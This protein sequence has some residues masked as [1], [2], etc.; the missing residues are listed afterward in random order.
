MRVNPDVGQ[1]E[2]WPSP[3][4]RGAVPATRLA[5]TR[6]IDIPLVAVLMLGCGIW[7]NLSWQRSSANGLPFF[8]Q[9]YFE[10]AVMI[11]CGHGFVVA[12][13]QIPA[14]TAFLE[15]RVDRYSCGDIP[16]GTS[17]GATGL[18]QG[19]WRYLLFT[20]GGAWRVLGISW[21]GLGPLFGLLF[22]VSAAALYAVFRLGMTPA[23]AAIGVLGLA[24]SHLQ[25]MYLPILRDYAKAPFTLIL[26]GLLGL[27]VR[28]RP[29]FPTTLALAAAY[30]AVLGV[31]YGFRTDFL[32]DIPPFLV[33]L[34]CFMEGG[35]F[36]H[37]RLKTAAALLCA[38]TF[39]ATAWP[40]ISTVRDTGGCQWHTMLLGFPTGFSR[41]L[42]LLEAPYK[43]LRVYSDEFVYATAASYAARVDPSVGTIGYCRPAY[44]AATARYLADLARQFPADMIVRAY[45]S[46]LRIV[47]LP[48]SWHRAPQAN[49]GQQLPGPAG[50]HGY[51]LAVVLAAIAIAA[52]VDVRLGLFLVFFVLYFGGYPAVQF[53]TRHYFHLEFITW[54]AGGF[55]GESVFRLCRGFAADRRSRPIGAAPLRAATA[56]L[57]GSLTM[58]IAALWGARAYQQ[59]TTRTLFESYLNSAKDELSLQDTGAIDE[60]ARAL[61]GAAQ[62]RADFLQVDVNPWRC[63]GDAAVTFQYDRASRRLF[64]RKFVVRHDDGVREPTH[65]FTPVYKGFQNIVL[66][67]TSPGCVNAAYRVRDP[68]ALPLLLEVVLSPKWRVIPRY[69]QF[70]P[71][72]PPEVE[73]V[74]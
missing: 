11:A 8:Y 2:D 5:I 61:S 46:I 45:G 58:M 23:P 4:T 63:V 32:V 31:G 74:P 25:L 69:Q 3:D 20:V 37:L 49:F 55:V 44:D 19:A 36:R 72:G 40:I 18:Y 1:N 54:W 27:I 34:V 7:G 12:Q 64:S 21:S 62:E 15:Q 13:P 43:L 56:V 47:E 24:V 26:I 17:L 59:D 14:M 73:A 33:V 53:Q 48:L 41:P 70:G 6:R 57:V 30:G 16:A 71:V 28:H 50:L 66:S 52:A 68:N 35:V 9:T 29:R 38:A 42:G 10:P 22:A 67:D 60:I 51:G 65:I 39:A